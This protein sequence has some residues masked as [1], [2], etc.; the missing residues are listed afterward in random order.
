MT[1]TRRAAHRRARSPPPE[2][3]E[4]T[5]VDHAPASS[6]QPHPTARAPATP[7]DPGAA[8]ELL[9]P[10]SDPRIIARSSE[11]MREI[12]DDRVTLTVTSPP[13]WNAIDYDAYAKAGSFKTRTYA[14]GFAPND[15]ESYLGL[16]QRVFREV[17]RVT[18]P[19]GF[20]AVVVA[21][22]QHVGRCYPIP[23]DL[24]TRMQALGWVFYHE[25]VWNKCRS[26]MD[27]GGTFIRYGTPSAYHPN[28]L[29]EHILVFRKNGPKLFGPN[30][31]EPIPRTDL[32]KL[33]VVN[34]LWHIA[35]VA[36]GAIAHPCPFP[37][38]IPHR[39]IRLYSQ[40]GD[41]VLDP[42]CGSG[43]TGKAAVALGRRFVGYEI[44]EE[45]VHCAR[46]R[47]REPLGLRRAQLLAKYIHLEADPFVTVAGDNSTERDAP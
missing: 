36:G 23:F 18:R 45:F 19:G 13:Y 4:V 11:S 20:C 42:F 6:A 43:Q 34:N 40:R 27:R 15:Y 46:Q 21:S 28:V 35:P 26:V 7:P 37:V 8:N 25:I 5:P 9:G 39:L 24:T 30:D 1:A 3:P 16:M 31:P 32:V 29:T 10:S 22:I 44:E 38:E 47:L 2:V 14:K 12:G 41:L 17:Y 33:D